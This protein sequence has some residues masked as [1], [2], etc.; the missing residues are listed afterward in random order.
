MSSKGLQLFFQPLHIQELKMHVFASNTLLHIHSVPHIHPWV[1]SDQFSA[2][3]TYLSLALMADF[4]LVPNHMLSAKGQVLVFCF[5]ILC[6]NIAKPGIEC[7]PPTWQ[8]TSP[9]LYH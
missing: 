7:E 2:V 5:N 3:E 6:E 1:I 8:A 4:W 9:P